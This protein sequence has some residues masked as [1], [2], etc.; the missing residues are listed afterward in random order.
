MRVAMSHYPSTDNPYTQKLGDELRLLGVEVSGVKS[1]AMFLL[2]SPAALRAEVLHVHWPEHFVVA[3]SYLKTLA[4]STAFLLQLIVLRLLG[5]RIFWTVHNLM[6]HERRHARTQRLFTCIMARLANHLFVHG[7]VA[8]GIVA[9]SFGVRETKICVIAHPSYIGEYPNDTNAVEARRRLGIPPQAFVFLFLG[10]IRAYKGLE[11]LIEAFE[12]VDAED[13]RLVVAGKP[14]SRLV[15]EQVREDVQKDQRIVYFPGR[16]EGDDLQ[17]FYHS[18]NAVVLPF[19]E[20]LTSG[21]LLLAMS[22]GKPVIL[23]DV[24]TL[25]ETA[26]GAAVVYPRAGGVRAITVAMQDCLRGR[27]DLP[28]MGESGH[29]LAEHRTWL[30]LAQDT[31]TTYKSQS[32]NSRCEMLD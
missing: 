10:Q 16:V 2:K 1:S 8:A 19:G 27:F 24:P 29:Q 18:A 7:R 12:R 26:G 14:H 15:D 21:S 3:S 22:F 4:K 30:Q 32:T 5:T 31:L 28:A 25:C 6:E 11:G 17:F 20:V 23:P 13:A 9:E